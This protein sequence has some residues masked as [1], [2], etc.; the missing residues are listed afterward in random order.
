MKPEVTYLSLKNKRLFDG[1]IVQSDEWISHEPV[2]P[3]GK[4]VVTSEDFYF[5]HKVSTHKNKESLFK[6]WLLYK[7]RTRKSKESIS[8]NTRKQV[9]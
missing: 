9:L 4:L 6:T 1:G 8:Q 7:I 2:H 3:V 5:R